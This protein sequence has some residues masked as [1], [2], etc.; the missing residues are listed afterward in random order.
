MGWEIAQ[1]LGMTMI[2]RAQGKH[3]LLFSGKERFVA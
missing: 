1:R 3:Y 2:G